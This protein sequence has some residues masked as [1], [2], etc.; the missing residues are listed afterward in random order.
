MAGDDRR[1]R[2]EAST[3]D[4]LLPLV[5]LSIGGSWT[6]AGTFGVSTLLCLPYALFN[7]FSPLLSV[8]HD[9]TG[10]RIERVERV[11]QEGEPA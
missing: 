4:A 9:F 7:V 6:T 8:I 1:A 3:C 11:L 2:R 5:P 10:F